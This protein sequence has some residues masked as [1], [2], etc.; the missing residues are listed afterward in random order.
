MEAPPTAE[1]EPMANWPT[2]SLSNN[3]RELSVNLEAK[4]LY[5]EKKSEQNQQEVGHKSGLSDYF[6]CYLLDVQA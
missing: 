5:M 4:S 3:R 6:H 2:A 1:S